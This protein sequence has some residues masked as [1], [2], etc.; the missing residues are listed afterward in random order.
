MQGRTIPS[1][2]NSIQ[3]FPF[4]NWMKEMEI[5]KKLKIKKLQWIYQNNKNNKNP[6]IIKNFFKKKIFFNIIFIH[7]TVR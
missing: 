3:S 6:L 1:E 7:S 2:N 5:L 4:K